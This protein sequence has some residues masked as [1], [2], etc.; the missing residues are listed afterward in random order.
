MRFTAIIAAMPEEVSVLQRRLRDRRRLRAG[1]ASVTLGTLGGRPLAVAVVGDGADNARRGTRALLDALAVE[2]ALLVGVSGGLSPALAPAALVVARAVVGAATIAADPD[3]VEL[4]VR[5][6]GAVRGLAVSVPDLVETPVQKAVLRQGLPDEPLVVDLESAAV[7]E[8]LAS[9]GIPWNVLRAVSDTAWET[10]PAIVRRS[11][12]EGGLHRARMVAAALRAPASALDLVRLGW[13][14]REC[15]HALA[16]AIE[17]VLSTPGE[18]L[19][20]PTS[21]EGTTSRG[22]TDE[23]NT[24][25]HARDAAR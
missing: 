2:R 22:E 1:D 18:S 25:D 12:D 11:R 5:A 24:N 15:A 8:E 6:T 4:V 10:L 9:V 7:V 3:G 14:M 19:T 16:A 17:G 13:R 21:A 23:R 20:L